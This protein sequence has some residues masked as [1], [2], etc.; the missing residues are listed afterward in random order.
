MPDQLMEEQPIEKEGPSLEECGKVIG[1]QLNPESHR[2]SHV[3]VDNDLSQ[4]IDVIPFKTNLVPSFG[5][6]H[7]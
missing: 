3:K 1:N 4:T 5:F 6:L 2:L 7:Q